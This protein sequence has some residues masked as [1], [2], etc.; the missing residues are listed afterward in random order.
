MMNNPTVTQMMRIWRTRASVSQGEEEEEEERIGEFII[1]CKHTAF[2]SQCH[3][4]M[5][6]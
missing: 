6:L 1:F 5:F 4:S 3:G 2:H